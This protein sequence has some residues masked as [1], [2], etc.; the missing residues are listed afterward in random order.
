MSARGHPRSGAGVSP[1]ELRWIAELL[2]GV[3][4]V[5][6]LALGGYETTRIRADGVAEICVATVGVAALGVLGW[7]RPY[8]AGLL[9]VVPVAFP[10]GLGSAAFLVSG[11]FE[12][13]HS[14]LQA[15]SLGHAGRVAFAYGF[16]VG[17]PLLAGILFMRAGRA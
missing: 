1:F 13:P 10:L 14:L 6:W 17:V 3:Y 4:L 16:L 12:P 7:W 5:A 8:A 9:L 2:L 15:A 11:I